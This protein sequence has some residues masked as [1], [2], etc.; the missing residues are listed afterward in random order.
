MRKLHTV[1]LT[2]LPNVVRFRKRLLFCS[3]RKGAA[4][5][6]QSGDAAVAALQSQLAERNGDVSQL[7][8]QLAEFEASLREGDS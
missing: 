5:S 7:R 2:P 1:L 6:K 4:A 3:W 8:A